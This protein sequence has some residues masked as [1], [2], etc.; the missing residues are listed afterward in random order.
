[1][2]ERIIVSPRAHTS[3]SAQGNDWQT[4]GKQQS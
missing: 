1:M 2:A 3:E 4:S